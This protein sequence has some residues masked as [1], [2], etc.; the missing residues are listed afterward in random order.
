MP[1]IPLNALFNF[2]L[3]MFPLEEASVA[4]SLN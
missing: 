2:E 4:S 1:S 3:V